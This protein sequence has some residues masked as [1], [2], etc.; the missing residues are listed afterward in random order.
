M[1][2]KCDM[3]RSLSLSRLRGAERAA[4]IPAEKQQEGLQTVFLNPD[5]HFFYF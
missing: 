5:A 2:L 3:S 1:T 4:H